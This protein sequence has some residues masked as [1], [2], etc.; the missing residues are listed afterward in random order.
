MSNRRQASW[1]L[2]LIL[3]ALTAAPLGA[4]YL[5]PPLV[6][7]LAGSDLVA[8]GVI[9]TLHSSTFMLALETVVAGPEVGSSV[10]IRR[11]ED[12]ACSARWHPYEVGQRVIVFAQAAAD[13]ASDFSLR[14]AGAE[15][16]FPIL[17][18]VVMMHGYRLEDMPQTTLESNVPAH[19]VPLAT[20]L[21]AVRG[22]RACFV[23]ERGDVHGP[24]AR[25]TCSE[26]ELAAFRSASTFHRH[27]ATEALAFTSA[28]QLTD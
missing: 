27:L 28:D 1:L 6:D 24:R 23:I 22:L 4:R 18:G 12:W 10:V 26:T 14:S 20:F 17:D 11:F 7:L 19:P 3:L 16:E 9:S 25:Q 8:V 15:G 21:G 2:P 13:D 5:P